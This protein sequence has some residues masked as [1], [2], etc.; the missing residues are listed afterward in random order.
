MVKFKLDGVN[1]SVK[2][3]KFKDFEDLISSL[4]KKTRL[5]A[6]SIEML[7]KKQGIDGDRFSKKSVKKLKKSK[8]TNTDN[9]GDTTG[10]G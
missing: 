5:N 6:N 2:L 10:K 9:S 4:D 7:L 3:D 8:A 1:Y